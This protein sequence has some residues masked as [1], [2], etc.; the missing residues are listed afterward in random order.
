MTA[1]PA[2]PAIT[3]TPPLLH[4]AT[5]HDLTLRTAINWV[6][7]EFPGTHP[8]VATLTA[9]AQAIQNIGSEVL[10]TPNPTVAPSIRLPYDTQA[11]FQVLEGERNLSIYVFGANSADEMKRL[12]IPAA[13]IDKVMKERA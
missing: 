7:S 1:W 4:H 2:L 9:S 10:F 5:G 11:G 12:I 13:T 8:D 3:M 6:L